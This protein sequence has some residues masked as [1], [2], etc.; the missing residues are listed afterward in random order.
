MNSILLVEDD[1]LVAHNFSRMLTAAGYRTTTARTLAEGRRQIAAEFAEFDLLILDIGLPDGSGL[2]LA[3]ELA[4][5]AGDAAASLLPFIVLTA[6]EDDAAVSA[7]IDCGAYAYLV[8]PVSATQLLPLVASALA[9]LSRQTRQ[10]ARLTAAISSNRTI[11]AATGMLVERR[12]CTAAEAFA[13]MRDWA[14]RHEMRVE[15]L[16]ERILAGETDIELPS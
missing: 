6:Y 5:Q 11:G 15:N 12:G 7:A 1:A 16:A 4:S 14:R 8:K 10:T 3:R 13:L 2:L 9:S